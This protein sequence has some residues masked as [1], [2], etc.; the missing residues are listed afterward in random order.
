MESYYTTPSTKSIKNTTKEDSKIYELFEK[1]N[2]T[3]T[4]IAILVAL[5]TFYISYFE[6]KK[7][8]KHLTN[9]KLENS[10]PWLN[11]KLATFVNA[12]KA[13][14]TPRGLHTEKELSTTDIDH[15]PTGLKWRVITTYNSI[16]VT[17]VAFL[18]HDAISV[19][20]EWRPTG[21]R[22]Y[23]LTAHKAAALLFWT[24]LTGFLTS[25]Y[26]A[27]RKLD[28]IEKHLPNCSIVTL[29]RLHIGNGWKGRIHRLH[30]IRKMLEENPAPWKTQIDFKDIRHFPAELKRWVMLP[31]QAMTTLV[32]LYLVLKFVLNAPI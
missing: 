27:Y 5:S 15:F 12:Y 26:V 13:L 22:Y 29:N 14:T 25:L 6:T 30:A 18:A 1:T 17:F 10:S 11:E 9:C 19:I 23:S 32:A 2:E 8:K 20:F 31:M 4:S 24:G 3:I 21:G 16:V 7:L 28:E